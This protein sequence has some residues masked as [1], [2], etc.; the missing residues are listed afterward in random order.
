MWSILAA[1]HPVAQHVDRQPNYMQFEN[2][3]DF[4]GIDFP[5]TIDK[6]GKF[7]RQ[8]NISVK[9]FGFENVLFPIYIAKEHSHTHVNLLLLSCRFGIWILVCL[10]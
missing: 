7:E 8:N 3:L 6:I 2:E 9:V 10:L 5:V 1:L 4:S